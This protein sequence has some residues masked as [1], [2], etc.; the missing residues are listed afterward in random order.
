MLW[1]AGASPPNASPA[2]AAMNQFESM[3]AKV[4]FSATAQ[5]APLYEALKR[6][7]N[8]HRGAGNLDEPPPPKAPRSQCYETEFESM[9]GSQP[10]WDERSLPNSSCRTRTRP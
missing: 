9:V 10:L 3:P 8:Q 6:G 2:S 1:F 7:S 5:C 4:D